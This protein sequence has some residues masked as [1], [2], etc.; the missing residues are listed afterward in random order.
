ATCILHLPR[1]KAFSFALGADFL[2][3]VMPPWARWTPTKT[4][5]YLRLGKPILAHV[6]SDGDA[7]QIVRESGAGYV[8][9]YDAAEL[10][11]QLSTIFNQ[12]HSGNLTHFNPKRDY[13]AQ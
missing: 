6:P 2:Y 7:A 12:W 5:D 9:S 10:K 11:M 4:Y 3:V 1:S 8:L 13:I